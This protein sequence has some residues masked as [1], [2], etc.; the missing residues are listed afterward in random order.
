MECHTC[1]FQHVTV[2][3]EYCWLYE[4]KRFYIPGRFTDGCA[5]YRTRGEFVDMMHCGLLNQVENGKIVKCP[6]PINNDEVS[7]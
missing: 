7:K 3:S 5:A 1:F 6:Y 2:N 4:Y